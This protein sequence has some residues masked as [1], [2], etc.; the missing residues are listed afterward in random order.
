M[1][2]TLF[3]GDAMHH[4]AEDDRRHDHPDEP[5]E[6]IAEL[7][8]RIGALRPDPAHGYAEQDGKDDLQ[9]QI[10]IETASAI[11]AGAVRLRRSSFAVA[12]Q[13]A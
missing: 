9:R 4:R 2:P 8:Q 5:V 1:R 7:H 6:Q 3:A 10:L 11:C 12:A 13:D